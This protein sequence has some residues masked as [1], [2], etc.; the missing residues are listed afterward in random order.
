MLERVWIVLDFCA[1]VSSACK[2]RGADGCV[3]F[4]CC[5][6]WRLL[7]VKVPATSRSARKLPSLFVIRHIGNKRQQTLE[8]QL[9]EHTLT[10]KQRGQLMSY[11]VSLYRPSIRPLSLIRPARH[12]AGTD[13][14]ILLPLLLVFH[15]TLACPEHGPVAVRDRP[16]S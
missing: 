2:S 3:L 7:K 12:D 13:S 16:S 8:G 6:S 4:A 1:S 10:G 5:R 11:V 14:D 15:H 9:T